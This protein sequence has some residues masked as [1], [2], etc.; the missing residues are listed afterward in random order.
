[1]DRSKYLYRKTIAGE[2]YVYF[3][4]KGK[5]TALPSNESA[6]EFKAAYDAALRQ[7]KIAIAIEPTVVP[8]NAPNT[9]TAGIDVYLNSSDY[10]QVKP[11][12]KKQ[13]QHTLDQIA[14]HSIA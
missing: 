7:I 8:F 4:F 1:M 3:R 14:A 2:R 11:R 10:N 12:T 9:L 13:Y 5:L 6:D